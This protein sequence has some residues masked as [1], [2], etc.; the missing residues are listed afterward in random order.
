MNDDIKHLQ[1][2]IRDLESKIKLD[3]DFN[4]EQSNINED[5]NDGNDPNIS[6]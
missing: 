1:N 6:F 5:M 3:S 4:M 2:R